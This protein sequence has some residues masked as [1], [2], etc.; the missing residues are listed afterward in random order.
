MRKILRLSVAF[1]AAF[2]A[3][4]GCSF[5]PKTIEQGHIAYNEGVKSAADDELLLNI[6]RL[7]YF[8]TIEFLA[9]NSISAQTSITVGIGA[10]LGVERDLGSVLA[11]PRRS[12][13]DRPTITFTPQRGREFA[14]TT[15]RA[16]KHFDVFTSCCFG[17][18]GSP[19]H[20]VAGD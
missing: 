12:Y 4:Q 8:D 14:Q 1:L 18:A 9:T 20:A 11:L 10:E 5:G 19:T 15:R 3:C 7:R 2:V 6:V 17:M 13:S 16:N